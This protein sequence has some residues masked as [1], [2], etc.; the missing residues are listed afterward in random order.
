MNI[1]FNK[2]NFENGIF[3]PRVGTSLLESAGT[4]ALNLVSSP[5][6]FFPLLFVWGG[7]GGLDFQRNIYRN[8]FPQYLKKINENKDAWNKNLKMAAY[9]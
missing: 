7:G 8:K 5:I 1:K 6:F 2:V 9:A 3:R 4:Y